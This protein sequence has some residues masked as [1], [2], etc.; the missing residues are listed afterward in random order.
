[1]ELHQKHGLA[2]LVAL[3][4]GSLSSHLPVGIRLVFG[5]EVHQGDAQA[6]ASVAASSNP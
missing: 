4:F 6:T 3:N 2:V 1:M 5:E